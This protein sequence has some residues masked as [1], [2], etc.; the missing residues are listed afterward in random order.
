MSGNSHINSSL[1]NSIANQSPHRLL[2]HPSEP[3]PLPLPIPIPKN[4]EISNKSSNNTLTMTNNISTNTSNI[5]NKDI[6]TADTTETTETKQINKRSLEYVVRS[7]IA[8][9][10]A[11]SAA[12]T[13]IAP[14]DRVKI[15]FQTS[16]P[17]YK[18]LAGSFKGMFS[19]INLIYKSN[20]IKG[21]YQGHSATLLRI[22]PYAAIKFVCYEQIRTVLIPRD[23]FETAPRRLLAGSLAGV[24]SVFFTYP[25]DLI[26]VRLA[27]ETSNSH[28]NYGHGKFFHTLK[29]IY[30]ES[31]RYTFNTGGDLK[32]ESFITK[33]MY[34]FSGKNVQLIQAFSNFYRGFLPTIMGMIPYAGVSFYTHDLFHDIFRSEYLSQYTI[35]DSDYPSPMVETKEEHKS[36]IH[37]GQVKTNSESSF[38]KRKPL[39]TWAQLLA[40]GAAGML[41]QASAYPFEVIRRRMQ[42]GAVTN[43]NGEF[44]SISKTISLIYLE[45]GLKGFYVGLGIGFIKVVPMFA[46]SFYVYERI[47]HYLLL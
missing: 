13:L 4:T 39:K 45:K 26:R 40:G 19:A 30:N 1:D 36:H 31:P 25:L 47:K 17:H 24:L 21:L 42:V 5:S 27:F 32:N 6:N 18:H 2:V 9:G 20:G 16:N 37:T 8:G 15:L 34:N 28:I 35:A 11:G 3:P 14:L 12:K 43:S 22:F 44:Y 7:G 41:A 10:I 38:D 29:T 46:C 33:T 23:E